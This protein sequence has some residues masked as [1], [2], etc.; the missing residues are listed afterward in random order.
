MS[1]L[2][3]DLNPA[4]TDFAANAAR[5]RGMVDDLRTLSAKIARGGPDAARARC[6]SRAA[7][8]CRATVSPA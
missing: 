7:S 2:I 6:L 1:R 3:S 8:F 5:M 4:D